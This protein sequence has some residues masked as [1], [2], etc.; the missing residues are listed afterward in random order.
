[1]SKFNKLYEEI[2]D[3]FKHQDDFIQFLQKFGIMLKR[4]I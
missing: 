1:M 3:S 4:K 2:V